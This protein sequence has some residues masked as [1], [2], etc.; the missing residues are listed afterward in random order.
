MTDRLDPAAKKANP[1]LAMGA[2]REKA[3]RNR[4]GA[5]LTKKLKTGAMPKGEAR[6]ETRN[7][8]NNRLER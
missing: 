1:K 8:A 3:Q 4:G 5:M 2:N 6:R 7:P